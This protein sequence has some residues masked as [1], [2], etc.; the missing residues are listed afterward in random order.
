MILAHS[1]ELNHRGRKQKK[2]KE[3]RRLEDVG[4]E[5][6]REVVFVFLWS[7]GG[8]Q[9]HKSSQQTY[10]KQKQVRQQGVKRK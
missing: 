9:P 5:L 10:T 1:R 4:V 7:T 6:H 3:S 2:R 8:M